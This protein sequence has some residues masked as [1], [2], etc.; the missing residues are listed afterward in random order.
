M[1]DLVVTY[2]IGC[3]TRIVGDAWVRIPG[4]RIENALKCFNSEADPVWILTETIKSHIQDDFDKY[5]TPAL[6]DEEL[7]EIAEDYL[8]DD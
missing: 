6:S 7:I 3:C 4:E 5:V 1:K 8:K 2:N